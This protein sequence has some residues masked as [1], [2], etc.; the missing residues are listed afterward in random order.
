MYPSL[1]KYSSFIR[2]KKTSSDLGSAQIR[3]TPPTFSDSHTGNQ[4]AFYSPIRQP[5]CRE[6]RQ[7]RGIRGK[8]ISPSCVR[9]RNPLGRT[10][11]LSVFYQIFVCCMGKLRFGFWNA[12][13][14]SGDFT[15][16]NL[17][18]VGQ[19]PCC[20]AQRLERKVHGRG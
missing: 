19:P 11:L 1:T 16:A 17:L 12:F 15:S 18:A 9:S 10:L 14:S 7:P 8:A 5:V 6:Q 2:S 4:V 3:R 13:S 20:R